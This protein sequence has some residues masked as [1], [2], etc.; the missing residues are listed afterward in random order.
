MYGFLFFVSRTSRGSV[1]TG[2]GNLG[3]PFNSNIAEL[4]PPS[5]SKHVDYNCEFSRHLSTGNATREGPTKNFPQNSVILSGLVR[6]I[7]IVFPRIF[8][9]SAKTQ[10]AHL[11]A[12][13]RCL[14]AVWENAA[15]DDH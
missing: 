6:E 8:R 13:L 11:G 10:N 2:Q 1:Q 15:G 12:R 3:I 14:T 5:I 9:K 7:Q 4:L